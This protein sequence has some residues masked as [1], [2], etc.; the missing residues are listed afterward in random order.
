MDTRF[1]SHFNMPVLSFGTNGENL[2][3][4]N[5]Y[6]DLDSVLDCTKVLASFIMEWCGI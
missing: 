4:V 5:E 3:G 1:A 6:V 2:H